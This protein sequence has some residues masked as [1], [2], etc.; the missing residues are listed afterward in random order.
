[1]RRIRVT[2]ELM[3][4][5]PPPLGK[6]IRF[7]DDRYLE[8]PQIR[9]SLSHMRELVPT[10]AVWRGVGAAS[11]LGAATPEGEA[12]IDAL[13]FD[14]LQGRRRTWADSLAQTYTDGIIV[15]HRGVRVY[16]RYFGA[17]QPQRPHAC[18]SITKSY[19]ATL[20]ATLIHERVLDEDKIV[21]YYLPEMALDGLSRMRRC[22]RCSTC[23]SAWSTPKTMR[24]RGRKSG[25]TRAPAAART[26]PGLC[27]ARQ[28]LRIPGH[29][30][31]SGRAR[32][33]VRLQDRQHR[34]V[35]LG[36]GAR[37]RRAVADMLSERIW[38]RIGCEED[39][40]L[41]VDSI[42][43]AMGGGGLE[44]LSA[45]YVPLRRINAL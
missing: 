30:A 32:R 43:V 41:A 19:A 2:L 14:D 4:G 8:F 37:L 16:E 27:R 10:A 25:T 42:G 45:R 39:G 33:S 11:D 6:R 7:E 34:S 12:R 13:T 15:L 18:F 23:R 40:Y 9:W 20:A 31:P 38:S 44:R 36:H 1:M 17:L 29:A 21:P 35:V 5:S 26:P 24:I 22:A 28:L 3:Q